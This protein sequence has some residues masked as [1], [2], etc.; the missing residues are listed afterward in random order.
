MKTPFF[1]VIVATFNADKTLEKAISSVLSQRFSDFE[2]LVIDGQ[3]TDNTLNI[4]R[5]FAAAD[6]RIKFLSEADKGIYDAMNKGVRRATGQWLYFLGGDDFFYSD[7][8]L[9]KIQ[10][11]A[12]QTNASFIYGNV[13]SE[14]YERL[15]DGMFTTS[16]LLTRNICHQAIF[17]NSNVFSQ[18]GYY[19]LAYKQEADY[20]F[21][22]RCWL[23]GI[24]TIFTP[25]TIAFYAAGGLSGKGRDVAFVNDYPSVAVSYLLN[26]NKKGISRAA[27]LATIFRKILLRYSFSKLKTV[28]FS[29]GH[30]A[31]KAIAFFYMLLSLPFVFFYS[32]LRKKSIA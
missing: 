3:S 15:Y 11:I 32:I 8:V 6:K 13:W 16:R 19:D 23:N 12:K 17:Y 31:I 10:L 29:G 22:L 2:L 1:S 7:D 5:R 9:E 26:G 20:D 25:V 28:V 30:N 14:Q 27:N 24:K 18:L 4:V 21:N